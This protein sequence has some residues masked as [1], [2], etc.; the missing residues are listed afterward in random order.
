MP[1]VALPEAQ[2]IIPQ[3]YI[4][5]VILAECSE[6]LLALDVEALYLIEEIG[7][8]QRVDIGLHRVD[9]G[10]APALFAFKQ[11]LAGQG[12]ADGGH[13]DAAANVVCQK[14]YDFPQQGRVCDVLQPTALLPLKD[15]AHDHGGVD[16]VEQHKG[17]FLI[18]PGLGYA[19]HTAQTHIGP[20][21]LA[22]LIALAVFVKG[23]QLRRAQRALAPLQRKTVEIQKLAEGE[24]Q[25]PYLHVSA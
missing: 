7:L 9:A 24:G 22:K 13:G 15:V 1:A 10:R 4:D 18:Q 5:D 11:A 21:D 25:H 2:Q 23:L 8:E 6:K 12:A 14:Q 20:K 3:S 19:G 17:L 16:A